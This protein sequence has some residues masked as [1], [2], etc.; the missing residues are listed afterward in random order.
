MRR[1]PVASSELA[2]ITTLRQQGASWLRIE[3][4]TKIPRRAAKR[5]YE[6]W[7]RGKSADELKLARTDVARDEFRKHLDQL[8]KVAECLTTGLE[9]PAWPTEKRP[10]AELWLQL[11]SREDVTGLGSEERVILRH[12]LML[13]AALK[14]H[15]EGKVHWNT[16]DQWQ[17]EWD[18]C[19]AAFGQLSKKVRE[20][21][22]N[23]LSQ[24]PK[25]RDKLEKG[26]DR[27]TINHLTEGVMAVLWDNILDG[28]PRM[29]QEQVES[30]SA[31]RGKTFVVF[32]DRAA[33][34]T[35][36]L[37]DKSQAQKVV[38]LC[39]WVLNNLNIEDEGRSLIGR[40]SATVTEMRKKQQ[41]LEEMLDPLILTPLL[42]K[43][44]C[45]LCPV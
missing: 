9:V 35:L 28:D 23:I 37:I 19:V 10:A 26:L 20:L 16:L 42:L 18:A 14:S 25:T 36:T 31:G 7:E 38:D 21:L 22:N 5:A 8:A 40:L 29:A 3:R 43:T 39:K 30:R 6:D 33:K 45:S 27:I 13:L 1:R 32:G 44:R 15:T 2:R 41:E 17:A 4:E 12:N 34:A 11:W 24:E